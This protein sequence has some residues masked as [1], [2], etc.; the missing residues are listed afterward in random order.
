VAPAWAGYTHV[1]LAGEGQSGD[2]LEAT[3]QWGTVNGEGSISCVFGLPGR[4]WTQIVVDRLKT[5]VVGPEIGGPARA[6]I[7][8]A[9]RGEGC[10]FSRERLSPRYS[11]D[12]ARLLP[13]SAAR[14]WYTNGAVARF[15]L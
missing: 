1:R 13:S 12:R 14:V 11:L 8:G 15:L 7:L 9:A 6:P 2:A 10:R 5:K 4:P 3:R